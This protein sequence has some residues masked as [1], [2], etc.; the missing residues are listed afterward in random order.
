[1][2]LAVLYFFVFDISD[3]GIKGRSRA[4]RNKVIIGCHVIASRVFS[5]FDKPSSRSNYASHILLDI[6][7]ILNS[8]NPSIDQILPG[9]ATTNTNPKMS[10]EEQNSQ[11]PPAS[12]GPADA[13]PKEPKEPK[14]VVL[15][16]DGKPLSKG[17]LKKRAKEAE[18]ESG[19]CL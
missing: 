11:A 9:K 6:S 7:N 5:Y 18:S 1:M 15:G 16:E 3:R 17:E 12:A 13:A 19:C 8:C 10:A 14:E 2:M 4:K